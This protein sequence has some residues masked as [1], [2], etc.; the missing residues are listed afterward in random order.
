MAGVSLLPGVAFRS[1]HQD[2]NDPLPAGGTL[3]LA[4]DHIDAPAD[5]LLIRAATVVLKPSKTHNA[6]AVKRCIFMTFTKEESH[7]RAILGK[8]VSHRDLF[9]IHF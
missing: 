6:T 7:W 5:F 2:R 9:S 4:T 8:S 1:Y 3:I